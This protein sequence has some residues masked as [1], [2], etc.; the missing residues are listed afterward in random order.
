MQYHI[1]DQ[2]SFGRHSLRHGTNE[3][4][5]N[6]PSN[7]SRMPYKFDPLFIEDPVVYT[8]GISSAIVSLFM[9]I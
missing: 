8:L 9:Y 5:V 6:G 3:A 4:I 7:E 2:P 1:P